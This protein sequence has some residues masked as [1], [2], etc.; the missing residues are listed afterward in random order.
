VT[1]QLS[2]TFRGVQR[3]REVTGEGGTHLVWGWYCLN[4]R[5]FGHGRTSPSMTWR[6]SCTFRGVQR[7]REVTGAGVL[8]WSGVGAARMGGDSGTGARHPR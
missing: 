8:T 2:C 1:W 3:A 6:L 5:R 7:A 4:G